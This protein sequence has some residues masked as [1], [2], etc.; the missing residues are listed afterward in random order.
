MFSMKNFLK[1]IRDSRGMTQEQLA[2][3]L[4]TSQA[5][6]C[7][8]ENGQQ[9]LNDVLIK[10]IVEI[11]KCSADELLF[12][13][14]PESATDEREKMLLDYFRNSTEKGK[15]LLLQTGDTV[16]KLQ[17]KQITKEVG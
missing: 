12:G 13:I 5:A 6:I 8:I 9:R 7:K 11:L 17:D 10:K 15:D 3:S 2:E 1:T 16:P 14:K 4:G